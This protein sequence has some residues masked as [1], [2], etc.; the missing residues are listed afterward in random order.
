[1]KWDKEKQ[2]LETLIKLGYTYEKIGKKYGCTGANIKKQ[3]KKLGIE[4][5]VRR[6]INKEKETFNKGKGKKCLNCEQPTKGKG[7]YCCKECR[8][9][10]KQSQLIKKWKNGEISGCD[11]NGDIREFLKKYLFEKTNYKCEKCGFDEKNP[12]TGKPIIQI[13]HIDGDCFNTKE[14]NLQVLCPN[15]HAMTENFGS[16]NKN[17]TR[18]DKRTK[19][20]R[21]LIL[22]KQI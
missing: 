8:K 12:Y 20:Y 4:I 18:T 2:N 9:E 14:E 16:R 17:S 11:K 19:Y 10:Y 22:K 13:H 6:V 7:E 21:D 5:P 15:H 1:M 3:A